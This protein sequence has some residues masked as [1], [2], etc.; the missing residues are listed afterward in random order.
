MRRLNFSINYCAAFSVK[1]SDDDDALWP[2]RCARIRQHF[3]ATVVLQ[4]INCGRLMGS[5]SRLSA[6][7]VFA[8]FEKERTADLRSDQSM[9]IYSPDPRQRI[10]KGPG[11]RTLVIDRRG[12]RLSVGENMI[13]RWNGLVDVANSPASWVDPLRISPLLV[14]ADGIGR[15]D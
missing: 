11:G 8:E 5:R 10:L 2:C 15:F 3:F 7:D 14:T 13:A 6:R 4:P 1:P 12:L 9:R